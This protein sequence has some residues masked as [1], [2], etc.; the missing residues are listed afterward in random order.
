MMF[1]IICHQ[2]NAN[3]A[4]MR[5]H[6][7]PIR[8]TKVQ[9]PD[10]TKC[11]WGC[12]ATGTLTHRRWECNMVPPLW[13]AVWWFLTKP[14]TLFPYLPEIT[15]LYIYPNRAQSY[16]HT[17]PCKQMFLASLFIIETWKE[18][19]SP[20]VGEGINRDLFRPW[21]IICYQEEMSYQAVKRHTCTLH[22]YY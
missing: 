4:T 12:G 7:T 8:V 3:D 10:N 1:H 6:C 21:N 16:G 22:S 18:P 17:K 20:S 11:W 9:N 14:N 5:C 19:R 13:E 2:G 15:L